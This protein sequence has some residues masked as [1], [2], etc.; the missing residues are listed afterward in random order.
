[1]RYIQIF[2]LPIMTL[3]LPND[4]KKKEMENNGPDPDLDVGN[5]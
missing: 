3:F 5:M 1:M 2:L 4:V